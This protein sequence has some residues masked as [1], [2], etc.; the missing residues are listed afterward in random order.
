[1]PF[2]FTHMGAPVLIGMLMVLTI[3]Q[4]YRYLRKQFQH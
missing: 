4:L 3:A 1:M 2:S